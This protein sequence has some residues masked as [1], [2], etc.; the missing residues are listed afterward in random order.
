M[1]STVFIL[2]VPLLLIDDRCMQGCQTSKMPLCITAINRTVKFVQMSTTM[3]GGQ[4]RRIVIVLKQRIVCVE[5]NEHT[6]Y[7]L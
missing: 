3:V 4:I 7:S 1:V 2:F 5:Q 6:R